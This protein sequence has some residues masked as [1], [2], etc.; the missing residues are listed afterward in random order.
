M[1]LYGASASGGAAGGA[2]EREGVE[3]YR[4]QRR[5]S[6][7]RS[8]ESS[9]ERGESQLTPCIR[10]VTSPTRQ[11]GEETFSCPHSIHLLTPRMHWMHLSWNIGWC[12]LMFSS[13]P[14]TVNVVTEARPL[15]PP[16][17]VLQGFLFLIPTS[18]DLQVEDTYLVHCVPLQLTTTPRHAIW[19]MCMTSAVKRGIA[20]DWDWEKEWHLLW[21]IQDL[22]WILPSS[23]LN[24]TPCW[25]GNDW[26]I[27]VLYHCVVGC[28]MCFN[29]N[30]L[31]CW[32]HADQ[33]E[34]LQFH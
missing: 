21:T 22:W 4:E 29:L 3:H 28:Q 33:P 15:D 25:A 11:H 9:H 17:H 18:V 30:L 31:Q 19:F 27:N 7:D 24:L 10:N 26:G 32:L 12:F 8:R 13:L 14:Q 23:Q 2:R 5:R 34:H 1:S 6:S 16:V 20:V